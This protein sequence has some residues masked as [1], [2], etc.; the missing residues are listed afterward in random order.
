MSRHT[1]LLC[2]KAIVKYKLMS[3]HMVVLWYASRGIN[4]KI[5]IVKV[6]SI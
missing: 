1:F 3:E 5:I 2:F 6:N 4:F